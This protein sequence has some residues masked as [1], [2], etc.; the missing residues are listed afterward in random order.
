MSSSG[1]CLTV[2]RSPAGMAGNTAAWYT[3]AAA[4]KAPTTANVMRQ[5]TASPMARPIGRPKICAMDEPVAIMLMASAPWRVSTRREAMIEATDQNTACAQA[6][7]KRAQT[8][9]G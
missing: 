8:K 9:I 7:T 3:T 6:T 5:P 1:S 4:E 2:K